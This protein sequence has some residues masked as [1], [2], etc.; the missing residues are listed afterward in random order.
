[1]CSGFTAGTWALHTNLDALHTVLVARHSR[2]SQGSL[3]RGVGRALAGAFE[4]N[5]PSGG[6][7]HH[8]AVL[9]GD[10]D[11]RVIERRSHVHRTV[12]NDAAFA[13]LLEFLLALAYRAAVSAGCDV[14]LCVFLLLFC[15]VLLRFF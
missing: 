10:G 12:R 3:L 2:G 1:M 14:R 5:G 7:A 11:L 6:P 8:A 4:A 15:H 13:L 9:I